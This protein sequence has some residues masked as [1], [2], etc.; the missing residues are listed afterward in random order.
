MHLIFHLDLDTFFVSVERILDSSLNGKPVI[1]GGEPGGRGV[2]AACSYEARE[3]GLH[4]GMP[5]KNAVRLCPNGIYIHGNGDEYTRYSKLVASLLSEYA[6]LIEQASIDEFYM[7]FS[8]CEKIYGSLYI[9]AQ[10][11]QKRILKELKLPSSIGIGANKTIA[12]IASDFYKPMGIT[13]VLPGVEKEF[14]APLPVEVIP[15]VGKVFKDELHARGFKR[16]SDITSVSLDYFSFAFGKYG[17]DLWNKAHGNG[18]PF[19]TL[20]RKR[21]SISKETTF[22]KDIVSK[23][24]IE[25]H[26]FELTGKVCHSLRKKEFLASCV[27]LKLRYSDFETTIRSAK[28]EFTDNDHVIFSKA[29]SLFRKAYSRRVGIRLIGIGVTNF[30]S[31]FEQE[32][33]FNNLEIK[34]NKVSRSLNE[35]RYKYGYDVIRYAGY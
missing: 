18:N 10:N 27:H 30:I 11:I 22:S 28:I 5:I 2:V 16:I 7:D 23:N 4:S 6:P 1:V 19:I 3:Y 35:I 25:K 20:E 26:L 33:L 12:K 17:I 34:K 29:V 14:L 9:L 32:E 13:Y 31:F 21:K 24:E 8:G 15:G